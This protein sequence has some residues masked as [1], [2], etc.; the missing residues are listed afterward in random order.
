[1]LTCG[2]HRVLECPNPWALVCKLQRLFGLVSRYHDY[3]SVVQPRFYQLYPTYSFYPSLLVQCTGMRARALENTL[4]KCSKE[5]GIQG[6]SKIGWLIYAVTLIR[7]HKNGSRFLRTKPL[8]FKDFN[9]IYIYILY[10]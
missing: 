8:I 3:K 9:H 2:A 1:M 10:F 5:N 4:Y 6:G 7:I